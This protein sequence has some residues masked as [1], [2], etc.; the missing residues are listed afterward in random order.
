[1]TADIIIF[2]CGLGKRFCCE[3]NWHQ[4][5]KPSKRIQQEKLRY[6]EIR[7]C[8][9]CAKRIYKIKATHEIFEGVKKNIPIAFDLKEYLALPRKD[10]P[11]VEPITAERLKCF[12]I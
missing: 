12:A 5:S 1:M 9:R 6:A 2:R 3:G 8:N 4:F 11:F 10:K 7:I